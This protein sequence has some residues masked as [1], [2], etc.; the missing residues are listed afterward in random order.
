MI[1]GAREWPRELDAEA[2]KPA[3]GACYENAGKQEAGN[4]RNLEQLPRLT[5]CS[6]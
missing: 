4:Q 3:R 5:A 2:L 6:G 1:A